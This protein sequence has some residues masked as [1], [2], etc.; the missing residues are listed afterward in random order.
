MAMKAA[1]ARQ[2]QELDVLKKRLVA[3]TSPPPSP[4]AVKKV[5]QAMLF[6]D[7]TPKEGVG[8]GKKTGKEYTI[9]PGSFLPCLV[10]TAMNSDTGDVTFVA[11]TT[12][13]TYDTETGRIPLILQGSKIVGEAQGSTLIYGNELMRTVSLTL[14]R[15]GDDT[16]ID[17]GHAPV[18]N[19]IGINGLASRV[20]NHFFRL[21]G[22]VF[23]G[24]ALKGGTQVLQT[25]L[26]GA[27]GVAQ[28][29]SGIASTSGQATTQRIGP[30]L[31]TR[32]TIEIDAGQ[33]CNVI[34][35]KPLHLTVV[36]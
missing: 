11:V 2:Q 16:P 10:E 25:S 3:A 33:A 20:N 27:G 15:R 34:V 19:Q 1:M 8:T 14:A 30:A 32:P 36:H 29:A 26:A 13:I 35:V 24:G 22:A 7:Y 4:P 31:N 18:T 9:M 5:A 23:I 28:V 12:T 21:F 6:V 17:L